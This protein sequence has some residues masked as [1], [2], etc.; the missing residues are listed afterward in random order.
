MRD[1]VKKLLPLT[2]EQARK[3]KVDDWKVRRVL[4]LTQARQQAK[5]AACHIRIDFWNEVD[6]IADEMRKINAEKRRIEDELQAKRRAAEEA[7]IAEERQ[8]L[9]EQEKAEEE[10]R[11][12]KK[13]QA[14]VYAQRTR[15]RFNKA[16]QEEQRRRATALKN[17]EQVK[18]DVVKSREMEAQKYRI[19]TAYHKEAYLPVVKEVSFARRDSMIPRDNVPEPTAGVLQPI[20]D[21][22]SMVS[23]IS[24]IQSTLDNSEN[25]ESNEK[26][27]SVPN[28]RV[29]RPRAYRGKENIP[30]GERAGNGMSKGTTERRKKGKGPL[31]PVSESNNS[32][33]NV[34]AE[35]ISVNQ[36]STLGSV[37]SL[38][39]KSRMVP[40]DVQTCPAA[41]PPSLAS[42]KQRQ[43][44][45]MSS[46]DEF[47][48]RAKSVGTSLNSSDDSIRSQDSEVLRSILQNP[49][50]QFSPPKQPRNPLRLRNSQSDGPPRLFSGKFSTDNLPADSASQAT[51]RSADSN[52]PASE[53]DPAPRKRQPFRSLGNIQSPTATG[54]KVLKK[55]APAQPVDLLEDLQEVMRAL[56][57][58]DANVAG[59]HADSFTMSVS[60]GPLSTPESKMIESDESWI[61]QQTLSNE[62]SFRNYSH[63]T[64]IETGSLFTI[65]S[66][67]HGESTLETGPL[68]QWSFRSRLNS[69]TLS[70]GNLSEFSTGN[71]H[72]FLP[73]HVST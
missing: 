48:L 49:A 65:L 29:L 10:L 54:D 3:K 16:L 51:H 60:S 38:G 1:E 17:E 31:V 15:S 32:Q 56:E 35:N 62:S 63:L 45:A 57:I 21:G 22:S 18:E 53:V 58:L 37:H 25:S 40:V 67:I 61:S 71:I 64:S 7:K 9:I 6:R 70:S 41:S 46:L 23:S 5:H 66:T 30:P 50:T 47:S 19:R 59:S 28:V 2:T 11:E 55:K 73:C 68:D 20:A 69:S 34:D 43:M 8:R 27:R 33:E 52:F 36:E 42:V 12:L 72:D 44:T 14:E 24:N 4:R 13:R 39:P 26:Y